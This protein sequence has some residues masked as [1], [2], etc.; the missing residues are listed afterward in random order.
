MSIIKRD[1]MGAPIADF[2]RAMLFDKEKEH[3][4]WFQWLQPGNTQVF[5]LSK[6]PFIG[7]LPPSTPNYGQM[8][9]TTYYIF[10]KGY[11][12]PIPTER[13]FVQVVAE[14]PK[15]EEILE[16]NPPIRYRTFTAKNIVPIQDSQLFDILPRPRLTLKEFQHQATI[17]FDNAEDDNLH[18]LL[19]LQIVS[20]PKNDSGIGGLTAMRTTFLQGDMKEIKSFNK[21]I[22]SQI[23]NVFKRENPGY[24]YGVITDKTM[25]GVVPRL[26]RR[27]NEV[28]LFVESN[29]S[30]DIN[31]PIIQFESHYHQRQKLTSDVVNYQLSA[32]VCQPHI[33][34]ASIKA[35]QDSIIKARKR[36]E[37]HALAFNIKPNSAY[38]IAEAMARMTFVQS[39]FEDKF[40]GKAEGLIDNQIKLHEELLKG[41]YERQME[42]FADLKC[43]Y[44]GLEFSVKINNKI[45][46]F[47]TSYYDA[48]LSRRAMIIYLTIRM[49]AGE[50]G[51]DAVLISEL[52]S[53]VDYDDVKLNWGLVELREAGYI[54]LL[55]NGTEIHLLHLGKFSDIFDEL[56]PR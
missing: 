20:A 39:N 15:S 17:N 40:L 37:N 47:K 33:M 45:R 19:P 28:N 31:L 30:L 55:K 53:Q 25:E 2:E 35:I 3:W 34:D 32:L 23:P 8:P 48:R 56:A 9:I 51:A 24:Y 7:I 42:D 38:K 26:Y 16:G 29:T 12:G 6:S 11:N 10:E 49:L 22:L 5:Q 13:T 36:I 27:C 4:G 54:Y 18:L 52:K 21:G 43:I 1:W 46:K 44:D 14:G 41:V 50:I